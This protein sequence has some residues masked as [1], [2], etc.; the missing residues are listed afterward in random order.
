MF[1]NAYFHHLFVWFLVRDVFFVSLLNL[2][3]LTEGVKEAAKEDAPEN[4]LQYASVYVGNLSPEA[5]SD[6]Q[7]NSWAIAASMII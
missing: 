2:N 5:S 6:P 7:S 4:N 3:L 1:F